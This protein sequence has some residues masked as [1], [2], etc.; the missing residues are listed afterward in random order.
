MSSRPPT[1]E[2][3]A[4]ACDQTLKREVDLYGDELEPGA[5]AGAYVIEQ[6]EH[7]GGFATLYRAR[8]L[9]SGRPAA[10][11]LM[12][13]QL[14]RSP[15]LLKR[16]KQE[17]ETLVELRHPNIV[18]LFEYGELRDGRPFRAM[19]WLRG[20]NLRAELKAGGSLSAKEALQVMEE[21]GAALGAAHRR[22][23]VHRDLKAENVMAVPEG[24]WFRAKVVD[25]GL[26]K[27]TAERLT[28]TQLTSTGMVL[29]TPVAMAPEQIR[30]QAPDACTDIYAL[31]L[32][33]YQ[34]VTGRLP[35]QERTAV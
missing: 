31:G 20:R 28:E 8:H 14:T 22:G 18:E 10:L 24:A 15:Q 21:V 25:F 13:Q 9:E 33:L 26:V 12:H 23:V 4:H 29:G 6:R 35:V 16:F 2:P 7:Q 30:G 17:A 1:D 27:W 32:L 3:G 34:L 19:E 11:K 5:L